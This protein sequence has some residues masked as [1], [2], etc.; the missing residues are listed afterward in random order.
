M[1]GLDVAAWY[2][3]LNQEGSGGTCSYRLHRM[4]K[5]WTLSPLITDAPRRWLICSLYVLSARAG[6]DV[7]LQEKRNILVKVSSEFKLGR[8]MVVKE[9]ARE[10]VTIW[11]YACS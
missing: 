8:R 3:R 4:K 1:Y 6:S 2:E 9:M 7:N 5:S 11:R 10:A